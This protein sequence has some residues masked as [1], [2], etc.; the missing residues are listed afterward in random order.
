MQVDDRLGVFEDLLEQAPQHADLL[1]SV[2]ALIAHIDPDAHE[3]TARVEGSVWWGGGTAKMKDGYVWAMPHAKHVNLGFFKGALLPDPDRV[4]QGT[5]K[6]IRHVKL[7]SRADLE[8][9]SIRPLILAARDMQRRAP[10]G[11]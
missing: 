3:V 5:G 1:Q 11:V 6:L 10:T 7:H 8:S 4:L 9:P 2:R